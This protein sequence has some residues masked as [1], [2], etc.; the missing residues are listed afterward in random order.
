MRKLLLLRHAK[1]SWDDPALADDERPLSHRGR[2]AAHLVSTLITCRNLRPDLVLV[3]TALRTRQT[4]EAV[5]PA[6][7]A[8]TPVLFEDALYG[9]CRTEIVERLRRIDDGTGSVMVIGHNPALERLADS[10]VDGAGDADALD[11][12]AEKF[13]TAALAEI[14]LDIASWVALDD[15]CGTLESF[16]RPVD[17]DSAASRD[18]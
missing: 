12:L 6:L 16:T 5:A 8:A 10:L 14:A 18:E 1:S 2:R 9:A 15:G 4:W 7:P 11:R 3:S 17:L 13:P